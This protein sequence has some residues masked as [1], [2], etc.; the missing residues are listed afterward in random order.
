MFQTIVLRAVELLPFFLYFFALRKNKN[1]IQICKYSQRRKKAKIVYTRMLNMFSSSTMLMSI[2]QTY[3]YLLKA[4]LYA[5]QL[6]CIYC[7]IYVHL[8]SHCVV[9]RRKII[10]VRNLLKSIMSRI[11]NI[12]YM[13]YIFKQ[14]NT[15]HSN[16]SS[17]RNT[18]TQHNKR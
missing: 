18:R 7:S 17:P 8:I 1:S 15:P 9:A 10:F 3:I 11:L 2:K 16:S 4:K 6:I 12:T 13:V 14:T 5:T